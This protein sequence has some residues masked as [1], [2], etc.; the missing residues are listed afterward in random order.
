MS[1]DRLIDP[2]NAKSAAHLS[3]TTSGSWGGTHFTYLLWDMQPEGGW[4]PADHSFR[5]ALPSA[6]WR[7]LYLGKAAGWSSAKRHLAKDGL[8]C[9][10]RLPTDKNA[11]NEGLL[12]YCLTRGRPGWLAMSVVPH[13]SG[14]DAQQLEQE[15]VRRLGWRRDVRLRKMLSSARV[16]SAIALGP[17]EWRRTLKELSSHYADLMRGPTPIGQGL[18]FNQM[19]PAADSRGG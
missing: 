2:N 16:K 5:S 10:A 1:L 18:L 9:G 17:D 8:G 4:L 12:A 15:G 14:V 6:N 7:P 3:E 11:I 19:D 13:N